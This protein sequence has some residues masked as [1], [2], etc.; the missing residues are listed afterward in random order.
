MAVLIFV[1]ST[2]LMILTVNFLNGILIP[3]QI[4]R[5]INFDQVFITFLKRLSA[6]YSGEEHFSSDNRL[7]C[8]HGKIAYPLINSRR[9]RS[10]VRRCSS[11]A[12]RSSSSVIPHMPP[13]PYTHAANNTN[14]LIIQYFVPDYY[15]RFVLMFI[16][17][18]FDFVHKTLLFFFSGLCS[19]LFIQGISRQFIKFTQRLFCLFV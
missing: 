16:E 17:R 5:M 10:S 12:L 15:R 2:K 4:I 13:Y 1:H 7:L 8:C 9:S 11:K 3:I 18:F 6:L 19:A 14:R